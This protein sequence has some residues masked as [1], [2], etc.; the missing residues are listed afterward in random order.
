MDF[1]S[2][3]SGTSVTYVIAN[4]YTNKKKSRQIEGGWPFYYRDTQKNGGESTEREEREGVWGIPLS[5]L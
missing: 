1:S 3:G 5:R 2:T 4:Q